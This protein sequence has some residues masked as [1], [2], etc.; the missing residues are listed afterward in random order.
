MSTT[1]QA[2]TI[3]TLAQKQEA[4]G[5]REVALLLGDQS[6]TEFKPVL[7]EARPLTENERAVLRKQQSAA[8]RE[9]EVISRT[10]VEQQ[11]H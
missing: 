11:K 2:K 4:Q 3:Q 10:A 1:L 8:T 5:E 6:L 9:A 7:K